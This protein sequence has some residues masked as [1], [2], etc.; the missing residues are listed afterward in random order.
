M[1]GEILIMAF[2]D[3]L[4]TQERRIQE[5]NNPRKPGLMER[6][7][8]GVKKQQTKKESKE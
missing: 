1:L 5:M 8:N 4:L 3:I 2:M 6:I 7:R